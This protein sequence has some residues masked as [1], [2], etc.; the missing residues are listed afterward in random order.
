VGQD[1]SGDAGCRS[2]SPSSRLS[3]T[4]NRPTARPSGAWGRSSGSCG[5]SRGEPPRLLR[6]GVLAKAG[7]FEVVGG[8]GDSLPG[9][10]RR[11]SCFT[12]CTPRSVAG[13]HRPLQG[14][15]AP[16]CG[17]SRSKKFNPE[18]ARQVQ[19][20]ALMSISGARTFQNLKLE[21]YFFIAYTN[22]GKL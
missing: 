21:A 11:M 20:S 7:A 14:L 4:M 2:W 9:E 13:H 17:S 10:S 6:P 5:F 19:L 15:F 3:R 1:R 16:A 18:L 22:T 12:I 8:K